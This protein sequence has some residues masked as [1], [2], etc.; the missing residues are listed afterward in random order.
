MFIFFLQFYCNLRKNASKHEP[1]FTLYLKTNQGK[2]KPLILDYHC[3]SYNLA[4]TG[5]AFEPGNN[6]FWDPDFNLETQNL[7]E[8]SHSDTSVVK[9]GLSMT[10]GIMREGGRVCDQCLTVHQRKDVPSVGLI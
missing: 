4:R 9:I 10:Y 6:L 3:I 8:S 1:Q 5:L 2:V 7:D